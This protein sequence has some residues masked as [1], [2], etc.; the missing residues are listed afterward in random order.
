MVNER[1]HKGRTKWDEMGGYSCLMVAALYQKV[2]VQSVRQ[3][4]EKKCN[5]KERNTR[6]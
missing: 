1:V 4:L 3:E 6:R 5:V 2:F